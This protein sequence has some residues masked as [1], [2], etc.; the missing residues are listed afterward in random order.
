M[1]PDIMIYAAAGLAFIAIAGLG[2]AFA[3]GDNASSKRA[4]AIASGD[5]SGGGRR[6]NADAVGDKRRKQTQQM[7]TKLREGE[8]ERKKAINPQNLE[9]KIRQ[10]GLEMS[11]PTFYMAS[12]VSAIMFVGLAYGSGVG[13]AGFSMFGLVVPG[14]IVLAMAGFVGL[15][16]FPR[17]VLGFLSAFLRGKPARIG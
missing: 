6:R 13:T 1:S 17:F 5:S 16:G 4:R 15:V 14:P 3:G 11:M 9:A 10:A 8:K 7:L 2:L 12:L